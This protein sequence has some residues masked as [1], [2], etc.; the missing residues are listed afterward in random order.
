[1]CHC[2]NLKFSSFILQNNENGKKY[3]LSFHRKLSYGKLRVNNTIILLLHI[4]SE[5]RLYVESRNWILIR[6]ESGN[7]LYQ[8]IILGLQLENLL[9]YN[10]FLGVFYVF[11]YSFLKTAL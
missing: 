10:V 5:I 2:L 11:R 6:G 8:D 4:F 1:M 9:Q 3:F 7:M